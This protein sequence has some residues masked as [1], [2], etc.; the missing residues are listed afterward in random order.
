MIVYNSIHQCFTQLNN[1]DAMKQ[2]SYAKPL[3][4]YLIYL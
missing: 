2:K 4:T 1:K 3:F